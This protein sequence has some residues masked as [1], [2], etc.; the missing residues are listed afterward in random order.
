MPAVQF[1]PE[2]ADFIE[3]GRL[4]FRANLW[5]PT[6]LWLLAGGAILCAI[7]ARH[8]ALDHGFG[9]P[10]LA[11][12]AGVL[13]WLAAAALVVLA[14]QA[15]LP[16]R[17]RARL[18]TQ[19]S[20]ADEVRLSWSEDEIMFETASGYASHRWGEYQRWSESDALF[21]LF[22]TDRLINFI[23]KR[24]LQAAEVETLRSLLDRKLPGQGQRS[25]WGPA[26]G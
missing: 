20:L 4:S 11:L 13:F 16:A 25:A 10:A 9:S 2:E 12:F 26:P 14:L 21:I 8:V 24:S 23:P 1:T 22:F 18:R 15:L 17:A 19:R 5:R 6:N 3:A 7:V